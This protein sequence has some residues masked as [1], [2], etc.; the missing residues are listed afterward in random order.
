MHV[1]LDAQVAG[2]L[3]REESGAM[4]EQ[5]YE[6]D[7]QGN[8]VPSGGETV[9]DS[10]ALEG[11]E[12][13]PPQPVTAADRRRF[14]LALL[15]SDVIGVVVLL[16]AGLLLPESRTILFILGAAYAV[17]SVPIYIWMSRSTQRKVEASSGRHPSS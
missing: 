10:G 14:L 2:S 4:A 15:A 9:S 17:V 1:E 11:D 7:D 12:E 16:G 3:C 13:A 5:K 8:L 6:V